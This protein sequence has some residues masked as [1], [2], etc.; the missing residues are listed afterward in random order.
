VGDTHIANPFYMLIKLKC[1]KCGKEFV[2]D[3]SLVWVCC[4]KEMERSLI[5]KN[6]YM[7]GKQMAEEKTEEKVE[8][9]E[10]EE[11]VAE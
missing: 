6:K 11:V 4:H 2:D 1:S 8:E 5:G 9:E 10:I 3:N 7:E